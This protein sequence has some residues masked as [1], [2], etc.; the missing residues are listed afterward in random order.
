[1]AVVDAS[2][3]HET[4]RYR[5]RSAIQIFD[6][7]NKLGIF[8][9]A[10]LSGL[11]TGGSNPAAT[12]QGL[13][14]LIQNAFKDIDPLH[15]S[16]DTPGARTA[17][18]AIIELVQFDILGATMSDTTFVNAHKADYP[19]FRTALLG[20]LPTTDPSNFSTTTGNGI[21]STFKGGDQYTGNHKGS[22]ADALP[23]GTL[24]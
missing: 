1:M 23:P 5:L 2:T 12:P 21:A 15:M 13:V 24:G 11:G 19:T 6:F 17:I 7:M 8:S 9:D 10:A 3:L 14:I 4:D 16:Q 18:E 20:N 22:V